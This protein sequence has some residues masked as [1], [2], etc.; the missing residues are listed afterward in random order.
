MARTAHTEHSDKVYVSI[1][2]GK[3]AQK[4]KSTTDGAVKRYSDKGKKDV[5]EILYQ[6]LSGRI[7]MLKI[8]KTDYGKQLAILLDDVGE[9]T[10]ISIPVDSK[11]FDN[12]C[13]KIQ[14]AD[15]SKE[16]KL[17]PYSFM[18]KDKQTKMTGINIY[19]SGEKLGY[20]YSKENPMGKPFPAKEGMDED[21]WKMFKLQERAFFQKMIEELAKKISSKA[22]SNEQPNNE[23]LVP[24]PDDDLPF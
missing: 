17:A 19:Q 15:L 1:V 12:F 13:S 18:P 7:R 3:F 10:Q 20:Y 24:T 21:E 16:I 2:G 14:N 23:T 6:D 11:Y 8:E 22:S 4:V 9:E 5:Y